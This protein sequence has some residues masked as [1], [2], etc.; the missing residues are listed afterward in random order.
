MAFSHL[1][2]VAPIEEIE[3]IVRKYAKMRKKDTEILKI[4]LDEHIDTTKYGLR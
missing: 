2:T 3:P 1:F 4:L